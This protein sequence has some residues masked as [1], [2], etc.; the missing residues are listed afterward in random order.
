MG[1]GRFQPAG[2]SGSGGRFEDTNWWVVEQAAEA[3]TTAGERARA[4]LCSAYWRPIYSYLRRCGHGHEDAQDLTQEFFARLF[5]KNL[6]QRAA[7][8]KGKFRSWLLLLLKRF[9][10][11]QRKRAHRQKRGGGWKAL[12]LDVPDPT[13]AGCIEPPDE[14]SP[15][16]LFD[17]AWA[18]S[19]LAHALEALRSEWDRAG[20]SQLFDALEPYI[21]GRCAGPYPEAVRL[22][23]TENHLRV[24]VHRMRRRLRDLLRAELARTAQTQQEIDDE[25]QDLMAI[26]REAG[27]AR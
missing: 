7:R 22:G 26:F 23:L 17:R 10:A 19:L 18:E 21:T 8:H 27:A 12:A 16:K 5:E 15:D 1:W 20:K 3:A 11:D 24:I 14:L 9:V 25:L 4:H 6:V 13:G 2:I